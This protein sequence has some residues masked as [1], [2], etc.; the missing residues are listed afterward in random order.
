MT[1]IKELEAEVEAIKDGGGQ[2]PPQTKPKTWP[3]KS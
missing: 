2:L 3:E 1:K